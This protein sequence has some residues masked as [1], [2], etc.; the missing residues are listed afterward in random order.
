MRAWYRLQVASL[1]SFR[2]V[3]LLLTL[4]GTACA[5]LS[6][7]QAAQQV[8]ASS[9]LEITASIPDRSSLPP[10]SRQSLVVTATLRN[11]GD[12]PLAV[13]KC[14]GIRGTW[15]F[16]EIQYADR[17]TVADAGPEYDL[18][19]RP[20]YECLQPGTSI[21]IKKDLFNWYAEFG[22]AVLRDWGPDAY[23]FDPGQYRLHVG[24][25][26][27]GKRRLR[28]CPTPAGVVFSEWLEFSVPEQLPAEP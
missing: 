1:L 6:P 9:T 20:P 28:R 24:Y 8:Q 22:G 5:S 11:I 19:S 26:D 27:D 15:L 3:F 14:F 16:F 4:H 12:A 10:S 17:K 13:C 23:H 21:T 25:Y 18:F 2:L 7:P